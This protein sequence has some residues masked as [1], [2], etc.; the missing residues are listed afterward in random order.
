G[1]LV[2]MRFT[3]LPVQSDGSLSCQKSPASNRSGLK[4]MIVQTRF[5]LP[6]SG[7]RKPVYVETYAPSVQVTAT[8]LSMPCGHPSSGYGPPL[9]APHSTWESCGVLPAKLKR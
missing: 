8:L 4:P 1:D 3:S 9:C 7:V 2:S 6:P 5:I